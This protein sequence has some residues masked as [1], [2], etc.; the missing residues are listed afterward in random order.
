MKEKQYN[1]D[2]Y[3]YAQT[4]FNLEE[5]YTLHFSDPSLIG[6]YKL[7]GSNIQRMMSKTIKV[8]KDGLD[9]VVKN[10]NNCELLTLLFLTQICSSSGQIS[11]ITINE[12]NDTL[13]ICQK[14][15]YNA[16][17]G[18]QLKGYINYIKTDHGVYDINI[19]R[20]NFSIKKSKISYVDTN[21]DELIPINKEQYTKFKNLTLQEKKI[22]LLFLSRYN[23]SFGYEKKIQSIMNE[24]DIKNHSRLYKYILNINSIIGEGTVEII[25]P[26]E[27]IK[28]RIVKLRHKNPFLRG[29]GKIDTNQLTYFKRQLT[30][31]IINHSI[32]FNTQSYSISNE[33]HFGSINS[34]LEALHA[35]LITY[36]SIGIEKVYKFICFILQYE[37]HISPSDLFKINSLLKA[38]TK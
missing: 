19:Q 2:L 18:L 15:L 28:N 6:S 27:R 36:S 21:R 24:L 37:G 9:V 32:S 7:S 5:E 22:Y 33:D 4:E 16:L 10:I 31:Y 34:Y 26:L 17:S 8:K 25:N 1:S 14:S 29:R 30:K 12:L 11:K 20:N 38:K 3:E 23:D 35:S 13:S